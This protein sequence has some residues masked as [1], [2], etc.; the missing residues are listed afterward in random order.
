MTISTIEC[1]I[2]GTYQPLTVEQSCAT[3]V[4][5]GPVAEGEHMVNLL[6]K[7]GCILV[8]SHKLQ[9]TFF[10]HTLDKNI[11]MVPVKEF[12]SLKREQVVFSPFDI[13]VL[14]DP[15]RSTAYSRYVFTVYL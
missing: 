7:L 14:R 12:D 10:G 6:S 5:D 13:D 1:G 3:S 8:L 11:E 9:T 2:N 15:S 4:C